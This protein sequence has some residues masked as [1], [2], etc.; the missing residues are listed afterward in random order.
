MSDQLD[1]RSNLERLQ[2]LQAELETVEAELAKRDAL[3]AA[4]V[5]SARDA[6]I[7]RDLEGKVIAWNPAAEQMFGWKAEEIIGEPVYKIIP[8]DKV[9][10]H[11][12]W[13]TAIRKGQHVEPFITER[14]HKDGK[15]IRVSV[16][17]SPI[18]ARNGEVLGASA[19]DHEISENE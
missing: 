3:L 9:E 13:I 2:E 10:E 11:Q 7:A 6:I 17:V 12:R 18:I 8:D 19:I 5:N 1:D 16:S 15:R 4:I 14:K